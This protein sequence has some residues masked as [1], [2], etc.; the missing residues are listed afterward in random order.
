MSSQFANVVEEIKKMSNDDKQELRFLLDKYLVEE[1]RN[2][3]LNNYQHS[4]QELES[5][6][7]EFSNDISKL[8]SMINE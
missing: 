6:K 5:G 2:E 7:L 1:K 8:K 3:I 4:L